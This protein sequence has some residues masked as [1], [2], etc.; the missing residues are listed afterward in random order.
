MRSLHALL[1]EA[2]ETLFACSMSR[3]K[4]KRLSTVVAGCDHVLRDLDALVER[5]QNLGTQSGR[6]WDRLKFGSENIPDIRARL[7]SNVTLLN[8]F[9]R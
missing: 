8:G 5:Y 1:Q 9:I 7:T 6:T 2:Q 3:A 4:Q